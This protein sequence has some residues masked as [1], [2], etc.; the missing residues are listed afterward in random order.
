MWDQSV[1]L[2]HS[3][4]AGNQA[5]LILVAVCMAI[6]LAAAVFA[7]ALVHSARK[8]E[9]IFALASEAAPAS[10]IPSRF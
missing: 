5:V 2:E 4:A 9:A 7:T 1:E 3:Q 6:M 10:R 8:S